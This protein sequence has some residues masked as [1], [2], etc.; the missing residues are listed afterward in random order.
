MD[1]RELEQKNND[2]AGRTSDLTGVNFFR[3]AT[4]QEKAKTGKPIM[5]Y[6]PSQQEI[7]MATMVGV[8]AGRSVN[9]PPR[10]K[11][12]PNPRSTIKESREKLTMDMSGLGEARFGLDVLFGSAVRRKK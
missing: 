8:G 7:N 12:Y 3:T 6:T 9:P 1:I 11:T 4:K 2:A 5:T 10:A